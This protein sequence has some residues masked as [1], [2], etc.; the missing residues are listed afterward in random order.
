[1]LAMSIRHKDHLD[2]SSV[3]DEHCMNCG[4]MTGS[5]Q[6]HGCG[7]GEEDH[8]CNQCCGKFCDC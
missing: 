6:C 1:M 7:S 3:D 8:L 4:V 5:V 2:S